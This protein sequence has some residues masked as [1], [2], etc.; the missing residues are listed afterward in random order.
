MA[1]IAEGKKGTTRKN[2]KTNT[3]LVRPNPLREMH[4]LEATVMELM[5]TRLLLCRVCAY[6][7][8]S[9]LVHCEAWMRIVLKPTKKMTKTMLLRIPKSNLTT[10]YDE[11]KGFQFV[12][13]P[14]S[15]PCS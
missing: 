13:R 7:L 2:I 10:R 6:T 14:T 8:Y 5:N 3:R 11:Y 1:I 9:V 4:V 12:Q 15:S